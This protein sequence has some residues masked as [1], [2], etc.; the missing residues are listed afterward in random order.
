MYVPLPVLIAVGVLLLALLVLALRRRGRGPDLTAPPRYVPPARPW[1][2]G[3]API[4]DLPPDLAAEVRAL[5]AQNRKIDAIKLVREAT[6]LGLG[7]AKD[8][9]ER[10]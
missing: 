9:V 4:G 3:A 7:E 10:M 1:A 6:N 8:M 5:L 2:V